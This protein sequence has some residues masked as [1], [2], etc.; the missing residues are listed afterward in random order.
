MVTL[1]DTSFDLGACAVKITNA[2]Q[3]E[4]LIS[5]SM[6]LLSWVVAGMLYPSLVGC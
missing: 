4:P 3:I 6:L 1:G 2:L 5:E